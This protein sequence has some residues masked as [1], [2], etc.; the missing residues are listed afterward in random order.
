M[1][2]IKINL[3]K[4]YN[5]RGGAYATEG[6]WCSISNRSHDGRSYFGEG[7]YQDSIGFRI[8]RTV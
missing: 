3:E 7:V 2:Q 5:I 4:N 6:M 1:L 8:V